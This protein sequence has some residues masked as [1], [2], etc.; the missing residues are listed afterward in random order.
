MHNSYLPLIYLPL[1]LPALIVGLW[2]VVCVIVSGLG[3][4]AS[5]AGQ[6]GCREDFQGARW[7]F[8]SGQMRWYMG[9]NNCLTMGADPRGLFL[10]VFPLFRLGH[11]PLFIPLN[12]ISVTRTRILWAKQVRLCLGRELQIPLTIRATLAEK[13]R[14]AAGS[15]WPVETD[16]E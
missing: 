4:W 3:G 5:L 14:A 7:T 1:T 11:P 9:Y 10:A 16:S 2:L 13:L 12:E 6:Y 15:S 8:Q